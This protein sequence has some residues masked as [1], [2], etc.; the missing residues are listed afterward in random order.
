MD[1]P[2]PVGDGTGP[3]PTR[4]LGAAVGSCLSASLLFCM[5]KARLQPG[6]IT[7]T[8]EGT[9][10]RDDRNRLRVGGLQ[11]RI[12]PTLGEDDASRARRCMDVF[13]D[14]CIVTQSVR[15]G[16]DIDVVVEPV[17]DDS[18]RAEDLVGAGS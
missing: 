3:N 6:E 17:V 2:P 15:S 14:F 11:V 18:L 13:E 1:E 9:L 4:L 10:E 12:R 7:A 8:V 16:I 5:R